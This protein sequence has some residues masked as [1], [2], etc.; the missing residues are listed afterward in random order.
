MEITLYSKSD[1]EN[2]ATFTS[3]KIITSEYMLDQLNTRFGTIY[4]IFYNCKGLDMI[5]SILLD[6]Y[7][8]LKD[9]MG[10]MWCKTITAIA[11]HRGD[12]FTS[13]REIISLFVAIENLYNDYLNDINNIMNNDLIFVDK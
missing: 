4:D 12:L 8:Q 10:D 3:D 7:G 5:S 2:L 6:Y 13:D 1:L 9:I 11:N